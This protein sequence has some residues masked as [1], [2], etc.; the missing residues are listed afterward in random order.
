MIGN[1]DTKVRP[2]RLG[3]L[4]DPGSEAQIHEAIRL[5][6]S[7][8]GGIYFP[9][10]PL[11]GR[12][13]ANWVEKPFKAPSAT[14]VIR[15]YLDAFDPD[16]LIQ[17]STE[18]PD[19]VA[20]GGLTIVQ[21][22]DIWEVLSA[23][24]S[25]SPRFGIGIFEILGEIFRQHFRYKSKY[26]V[27]VVLPRLPRRLSLF[28]AAVLGEVPAE[29]MPILNQ[30]F[31]EP[32][33]IKE[34]EAKADHP[35]QLTAGEYL[36]PSRIVRYGLERTRRG[37]PFREA[38][39]FF[40]DASK[41][42]DIVDFWNLRALGP[43]VLPIPKQL[44]AN[45]E[46]KEMVEH[47]LAEHRR[48]WPHNPKVFDYASIVR[49]RNSTLEEM[50]AFAQTLSFDRA[51]RGS[52]GDQ[53]FSLQHWYPRIWDE[54]ARDKDG[55]VP[56]DTYAET[57]ASV[58]IGDTRELRVHLKPLLPGFAQKYARHDAPRCAN[59]VSFRLYGSTEY[60][61]EV[62]PKSSGDHVARAI[63]GLTSFRG[64][65][66]VGRNG[67]V[68][69][70]KHDYSEWRDIPLAEDLMLAWLSDLG[71]TAKLSAAGLLAK[72]ISRQ[73]DGHLFLL[74]DE[75]LLGLLEHMNGGKVQRDGSPVEENTITPELE[76]DITIAE[77]KSRL[78]ENIHGHCVSKD[79]FRLGSRIK[80]PHC[81]RNSWFPLQSIREEFACPKCLRVFPAAGNL[82]N[83]AWSYKTAGPFSVPGYADGAYAVLL[84]LEFFNERKMSTLR[85]TP[86][87]SFTAE[88]P[89]KASLEADFA[90]L[91]QESV[92]GEKKDGVLFGECK[93]YGHF[94]EGDFRR[95]RYLAE[96]F[97]GAVL[98]FSTLRK[99]LTPYE[100]GQITRI[101]KAG[102]KHW[103]ADRPL[104]PVLIL[105]GTELVD[106]QGPPYCWGDMEKKFDH[107]RGLLR[108]CDATQQIYLELPSWEAEWH[109]RWEKKRQRR[110]AKMELEKK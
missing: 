100:T 80:C 25:R 61:A 51:G 71:W 9:I 85:T 95:M 67:L 93:T 75:K 14:S 69:L 4:V 18:V 90:L 22:R 27:K 54:W 108:V 82:T 11:Y 20:S 56:D 31:R 43:S 105:T 42:E 106:W 97:P 15:G 50:Q 109:A 28:W 96:H 40:L 91:W 23:S 36:F 48:P 57:E 12:M 66:R 6:S 104:N 53:Y 19:L 68:R 72:Q 87:L 73:L 10:I 21:G 8:W 76:R 45:P 34:V 29:L 44:S 99:A 46:M 63:G 37:G 64:D 16:V 79:V 60:L 26:P 41:A 89:H 65:W 2:L 83:S 39:A 88:G 38:R 107:A 74:H 30:E 92:Y 70:V 35:A 32:L 59:D 52:P 86:L 110:V 17:L 81:L 55:A 7:L 1:I 78:A 77:T 47:F 98:V 49:S 62:F 101:A 13:P 58:D 103:R 33:E 5:S 102:R 3:Y 94:S 84:T 24:R